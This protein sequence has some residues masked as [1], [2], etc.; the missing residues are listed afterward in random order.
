MTTYIHNIGGDPAIARAV[1]RRLRRAI[2]GLAASP[3]IKQVLAISTRE[4]NNDP[5]CVLIVTSYYDDSCRARL[6]AMA[7]SHRGRIF[8]LLISNEVS[9]RDYKDLVRHG[10][11]D[12]VSVDADP[13]E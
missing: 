10:N 7:S 11:A 12:W 9:I 4:S 3:D 2:P 13:Q 8:F 6:A 5:V 1:E